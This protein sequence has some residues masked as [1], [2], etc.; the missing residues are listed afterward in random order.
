MHG[1]RARNNMGN[2]Q[3]RA[4]W[5]SEAC[6][7]GLLLRPDCAPPPVAILTALSEDID[8]FATEQA[9]TRWSDPLQASD[10]PWE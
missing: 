4:R 3:L 7:Q 1:Q 2:S 9:A 6:V 8:I 5:V 10:G